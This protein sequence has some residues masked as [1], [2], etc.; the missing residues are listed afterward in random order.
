MIP[1]SLFIYTLTWYT[2]AGLRL[3]WAVVLGVILLAWLKILVIEIPELGYYSGMIILCLWIWDTLTQWT[4]EDYSLITELNGIVILSTYAMI[5][6][7][8]LQRQEQST[9]T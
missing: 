2:D 6:F 5:S 3:F 7:V 9:E 4:G 8:Y 1:F